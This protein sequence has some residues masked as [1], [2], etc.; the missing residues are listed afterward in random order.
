MKAVH[1]STTDYG[2][3]YRAA[4]NISRAMNMCGADSK[5]IVRERHSDEDVI[6]YCNTC[7]KLLMSKTKNFFNLLVSRGAIINDLF[8]SDI[9]SM[10]EVQEADVIILH[11]VNS[12]ISYKGVEKLCSLGKPVFWVM[13]DMWCFT[14]G[15]HY[16]GGCGGFINNCLDA[17]R[18]DLPS[19]KK[20]IWLSA[21]IT[22][23]GPSR[24][25]TDCAVKS[26]LLKSHRCLCM[27]NPVDTE[28]FKPADGFRI[29]GRKVIMFGAMIPGDERKGLDLLMKSL[30]LLDAD[31]YRVIIFGNTDS[32][33]LSGIKQD[34]KVLG[35]LKGD[36]RLAEAYN[37]ADVFVIPSKQ[38]NLS[39]AVTEAMS[40][41]IPAVAFDI[42]GMS[43]MIEHKKDGYLAKPF[44]TEDLAAGIEYC[45]SHKDELG[46]AA[47]LKIEKEFSMKLIGEEYVTLCDAVCQNGK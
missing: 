20:R 16:D 35:V 7:V 6:P 9:T 33:K 23:I 1:I 43:D 31:R 44:D 14:G 45:V 2:G 15:C 12:F 13:H 34:C 46:Q 11:W 32:M 26:S 8:G 28:V 3:A 42:G 30:D 17:E 47:R 5:V 21:D 39:N 41:G 10:K 37:M 36:R 40:C 19:A 29:D 38:E 4:A 25:I 27:K 22:F 18:C 24:W